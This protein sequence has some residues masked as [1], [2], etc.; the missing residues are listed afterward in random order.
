MKN[1]TSSQQRLLNNAE[2]ALFNIFSDQPKEEIQKNELILE[3]TNVIDVNFDNSFSEKLR[4]M[5]L[6]NYS[7]T[8]F[9]KVKSIEKL[10][11]KKSAIKYLEG[12]LEYNNISIEEVFSKPKEL[13]ATV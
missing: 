3:N 8:L 4:K 5:N 7:I 2:K 1:L 10:V 9:N 6:E 13:L 12:Y 11:S